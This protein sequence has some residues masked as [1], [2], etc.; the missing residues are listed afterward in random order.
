MIENIFV[1]SKGS[2][3]KKMKKEFIKV[4]FKKTNLNTLIDNI[5][6]TFDDT[7]VQKNIFFRCNA[8]FFFKEYCK[9]SKLKF[10][11]KD[12]LKL[13]YFCILCAETKTAR[14]TFYIGSS[15]ICKIYEKNKDCFC[16]NKN[17]N[18][19][20][21]ILWS[22]IESKHYYTNILK[23]TQ[24]IVSSNVLDNDNIIEYLCLIN[25]ICDLHHYTKEFYYHS[26]WILRK[27]KEYNIN[28]T[29]VITTNKIYNFVVPVFIRLNGIVGID[30]RDNRDFIL[31][32]VT[33]WNF[34]KYELHELSNCCKGEQDSPKQLIPS[35]SLCTS[36]SL[37]KFTFTSIIDRLFLS[38]EIESNICT[39]HSNVCICMIDIVNFS[40]WC[41]KQ[42]PQQIFTTMTKYNTFL[43]EYID[44]Y[45]N[46]EKIEMVG[47]SVLIVGGLY[48]DNNTI[49]YTSDIIK[50]CHSILVDINKLN[51]IFNDE[52]VSIRIGI[53][54]GDVYSGYILNPKKFQ[55]FGNSINVASRLESTS[56][57]GILNIST[58]TFDIIKNI[59]I[60]NKF[61]I[62]R[63]N[64]NF[65]KGV[66]V[67]DSLMCFIRKDS[68]LIADDVLITCNIIK[69]ILK[70]KKCDIVIN[71][72]HCFR[73]LKQNSY[74]IVFLDRFF[75]NVDIYVDIK[76][77]RIWET[78]YRLN[79]QKIVLITS[80]KPSENI[81]IDLYI[82]DIIIKNEKFIVTIGNHK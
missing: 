35:L 82:D 63:T 30:Y 15:V 44:M 17:E 11:T 40:Q 1:L 26:N 7:E 27:Y 80:T 74:E 45:D 19:L 53:H 67:F 21:N 68:V 52:S 34:I 22:L 33:H 14:Q 62:G 65:L 58:K 23:R 51:E 39:T 56:F 71:N 13:M 42:E 18:K 38:S 2:L 73:L 66:G 16:F 41:S 3:L 77:F 29:I 37:S 61:E 9:K 32:N 47:D 31:K 50:L 6:E 54:N 43:N 59:E 79:P 78:K 81:N 60:L 75:D 48:S 46:V 64:T 70:H 25:K 55:L 76:D 8:L 12:L 72:K 28:D 4:G 20:N 69:K 24:H 36:L 5:F 10:I 57:P 49:K